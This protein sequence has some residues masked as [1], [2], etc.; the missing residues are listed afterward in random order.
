MLMAVLLAFSIACNDNSGSGNGDDD[1]DSTTSTPTT[2][3]TDYQLIKNGDFEFGTDEDTA[4]PY[5]SSI[6][7]ARSLYSD[8]TSAPSSTGTSG[9]IDTA[10]FDDLDVKNKPSVNPK[11]PGDLGLVTSEYD[12]EDEDKQ[13][14]PQADGTKILMINNKKNGEGTAQYYKASS[15][16]SVA[17]GEYAKLSFWINTLDLKSL[18]T[19]TPGAHI[20]LT[21]TT[22]STT[23]EEFLI[24]DVNT[25]GEW[26][27][28]ELYF[29][30][31][32]VSGT[33][34]NLT[35]GLGRGNGI[36]HNEFVEGFVFFDNVHFEKIDGATYNAV[37]NA[38]NVIADPNNIS[39]VSLAGVTFSD[40]EAQSGDKFTVYKTKIN[41]NV[42]TANER[43]DGTGNEELKFSA[44]NVASD[45]NNANK[46]GTNLADASQ[47]ITDAIG[48]NKLGFTNFIYMDLAV[49]SS[50]TYQTKTYEL[51]KESYDLVTFFVKSESAHPNSDKL[52]V[53]V[54]NEDN[55]D[56]EL[57]ASIDTTDV[58]S[59]RYGD[60]VMYRAFINNPTSDSTTY[61]IKF[62]Y[63]YDGEWSDAFALQKGFAV[64]ADL[65]VSFSDEDSYNL[66]TAGDTLVKTQIYGKYASFGTDSET[67]SS[68]VYA[69]T[70][71][72]TQSF[73][74]KERPATNV[75]GYSFKS[76]KDTTEY[77]IVNSKYHANYN[78]TSTVTKEAF[79]SL[80]VSSNKH[81]QA[82]VLDNKEAAYSR[83][84]SEVKTVSANSSSKVIVKVAAF[85]GAKA[86]VSI[87]DSALSGGKYKVTH[88][89]TG[90]T[91]TGVALSSEVTSSSYK[92]SGWTYVYFYITAGNE[93]I[94]FRVEISNGTEAEASVGTVF[95]EGATVTS[96]D[97]SM[98]GVEK[99][100]LSSDFKVLGAGYEFDAPKTHTRANSI[101]KYTGADGETLE[102]TI[103]Y[104]PKEVY[105]GNAYA[106]FVDY[107]TIHADDVIDNT[108]TSDS[109]TEDTETEEDEGYTLSTDV[110]LQ[111]SS[112][113]IAVV[114]IVVILVILI[115]NGIKKRNKRKQKT[116]S[117][118]EEK[119]GFDRNTREKT[120]KKIAEKKAKAVEVE[121]SDDDGEYDYTLTEVE[122][123]ESETVEEVIEETTEETAEEESV[124]AT[125]EVVE[126]TTEENSENGEKAE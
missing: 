10:E 114:L 18:Y 33:N 14:K 15:S 119:S 112:I 44:T 121:L 60:W 81:A 63:G 28:F 113:I 48:E 62:V 4:Y 35:F 21:S 11:T 41:Y 122:D 46:I 97:A 76:T 77:G 36:D 6:N 57:F 68:D 85:D 103:T 40:N 49:P 34:L 86:T 54:V 82:L 38:D 80:K 43:I 75:T 90:E 126:Q 24:N 2:E 87:V 55:D 56:A 110:A 125:E 7:W 117:Y 78:F 104:Q 31:S 58:E 107:S 100:A 74:V 123:E 124:E 32:E 108:T 59:E 26:A 22:G 53:K 5:S 42:L 93:D 99:T 84:V 70:V 66:S 1:D 13:S 106:K 9:I 69:V 20:K 91:D 109:T 30:G 79:E 8:V 95:T 29:E 116:A 12:Y 98:I 45:Y 16:I 118:Y 37:T 96:I 3:T 64:I 94:Q 101:E 71:D 73:S 65:K 88:F 17:A 92:K 111:V 19:S 115:R 83:F 120:L 47:V 89:I 102:R 52:K 50:A 61:S 72:K 67:T 39:A 23:Y 27:K 105:F 25:N 51:A